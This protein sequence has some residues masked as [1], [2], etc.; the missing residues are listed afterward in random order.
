MGSPA[1]ASSP[2]GGF[3]LVAADITV[4]F[5]ALV[6]VDHLSLT[7]TDGEVLGLVGPNGSGKS[8]FINAV[9]GLVPASGSV[10]VND[11]AVRL[12]TP[13]VVSRRGV[14][15]T[16]QT[17]QVHDE[18]ICLENVLVGL[19]ERNLRS[20]PAAWFRRLAMMKAERARW[21]VAASALE[22]TGL[23]K[24]IHS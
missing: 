16:F 8:T 24:K 22:F 6:A 18:L 3:V 15:R 17:P 21:E 12:G 1:S 14:L 23:G 20:L 2:R 5:G 10:H 13:G 19:P 4:N 9:T 11:K 7:I